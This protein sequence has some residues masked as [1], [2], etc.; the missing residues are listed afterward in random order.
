[1]HYQSLVLG[2]T[3]ISA[4]MHNTHLNV[5]AI[6]AGVESLSVFNLMPDMHWW[7]CSSASTVVPC[8]RGASLTFCM[9]HVASGQQQLAS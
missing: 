2:R 5:C 8:C 7:I 6:H 3:K 4:Y 9:C 1:M